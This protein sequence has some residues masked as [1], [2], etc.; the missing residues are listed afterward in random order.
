M[1]GYI[2]LDIGGTKILGALFDK[3]GKVIKL[4]ILI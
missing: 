2:G 1:K 3:N 4:E